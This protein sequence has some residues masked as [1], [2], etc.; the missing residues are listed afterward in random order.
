MREV[1]AT[2]PECWAAQVLTGSLVYSVGVIEYKGELLKEMFLK[3]I[4]RRRLRLTLEFT[5]SGW[6]RRPG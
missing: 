6:R 3:E 2:G 5:G 4:K 1:L